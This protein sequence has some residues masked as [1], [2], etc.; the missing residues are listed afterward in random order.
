MVESYGNSIFYI[1][2]E[3]SNFSKAVVPFYIATSSPR[4]LQFLHV[5][6]FQFWWGYLLLLLIVVILIGVRCFHH[7]VVCIFLLI[8]N[9]VLFFRCLLAEL[10]I[11][12]QV[13]LLILFS[14]FFIRA[15]FLFISSNLNSSFFLK[16]CRACYR[17][18]GVQ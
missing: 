17:P 18:H 3:W 16:G 13:E 9:I 15:S 4:G 7:G 11:Y 2:E 14:P 8:S 12:L 5:L 1:F 6:F 10:A